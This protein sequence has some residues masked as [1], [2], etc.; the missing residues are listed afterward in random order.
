MPRQLRLHHVRG[1][2]IMEKFAVPN[3]QVQRLVDSGVDAQVALEK[4]ASGKGQTAEE[5]KERKAKEAE[6]AAH[7]NTE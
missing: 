1:G 7:G 6:G 2:H 5:K 3:K 4:V